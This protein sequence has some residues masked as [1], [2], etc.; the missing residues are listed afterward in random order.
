MKSDLKQCGD[1]ALNVGDLVEAQVARA[2]GGTAPTRGRVCRKLAKGAVGVEFVRT[3]GSGFEMVFERKD[4]L[5]IDPRMRFDLVITTSVPTGAGDFDEACTGCG[6][7]VSSAHTLLD[8][9]AHLR[10]EVTRMRRSEDEVRDVRA[11]LDACVLDA[12]EVDRDDVGARLRAILAQRMREFEEHKKAATAYY[13]LLMAPVRDEAEL[14]SRKVALDKAMAPFATNA[15]WA[16]W[17]DIERSA[18]GL[19]DFA[20]ET[21]TLREQLATFQAHAERARQILFEK[22]D[23]D[24][25]ASRLG[26]PR[27]V[28]AAVVDELACVFSAKDAQLMRYAELAHAETERCRK[29]IEEK[30][31]IVAALNAAGAPRERAAPGPNGKLHPRSIL[32]QI[33]FLVQEKQI[34][35]LVQGKP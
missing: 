29:L 13:Q 20:A 16:A 17:L 34:A 12:P 26:V 19:N 10:A 2:E 15:A 23:V 14:A 32:E 5:K 22:M 33:A 7:T 35:F 27:A 3:D 1:Q 4:L 25:L 24:E 21:L 8:C 31:E 9:C 28:V 18:T 11:V 6:A 30:G